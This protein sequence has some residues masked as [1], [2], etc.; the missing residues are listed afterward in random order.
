MRL[1]FGAVDVVGSGAL[2]TFAGGQWQ[3]ATGTTAN[4]TY[5]YRVSDNTICLNY[6]DEGVS[7]NRKLEFFGH[8]RNSEANAEGV[9]R[10]FFG[11]QTTG[12]FG[13]ANSEY[14]VALEVLAGVL[15][16]AYVCNGSTAVTVPLT[17]TALPTSFFISANNGTV[18]FYANG[19][20]I[21]TTASG[22]N[23]TNRPASISYEINNG[24]TAANYKIRIWSQSQGY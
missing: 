14:Y 2:V 12:A 6:T 22:P 1:T 7:W 11:K 20:L 16:N 17:P 4:S 21:G 9:F 8:L 24:A 10:A 15:T 5:R 23:A 19:V 3:L 13:V 18:S